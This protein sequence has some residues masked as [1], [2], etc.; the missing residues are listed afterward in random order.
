MPVWNRFIATVGGRRVIVLLGM[1]YMALAVGRI[2]FQSATGDPA[3]SIL[4]LASLVGGPGFVLFYF[5]Y[6]LPE[7]DID[8]TFYSTIAAWCLG[9]FAVMAGVLSL[10]SLQPGVVVDSTVTISILTALA[11]TAGLG[12]GIY[13]GEAKTR[14]LALERQNR[15]LEE[16]QV[17]LEQTV[18][19]LET[20]NERLEQFAYAASHDLQ[21]PLRMISSYLKLLEQRYSEELDEDGEEFLEFAID[22]ADRMRSMIDTLLQYSRVQTQGS[23]FEPVDLEIVLEAVRTDL[24]VKIDESE[25]EITT[26]ALPTVTGD[27]RQ[28]RQ[29][30]QNLLSNAIE[31]SGNDRPRVHVSAEQ[32][33]SEWTLSVRDEG[34]GIDSESQDRIFNVF[35]RAAPADASSGTGIGLALCERIVERHNGEI[36]VESEMGA[37]SIFSFTLPTDTNQ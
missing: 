27:E 15:A 10:Y 3:A 18:A 12:I 36:W 33:G 4:I 22:G 31:Y 1:L 20:S 37:G 8:P 9:G 14:A 6:R 11:S 34:I 26:S 29:V 25:A 35:E 21:E 7:S 30:F 28:L 2:L 19:E 32:N 13:D 5:G 23:E 24:Q 17:E 16:T